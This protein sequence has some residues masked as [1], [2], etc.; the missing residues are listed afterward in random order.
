MSILLSNDE[1][2]K[3]LNKNNF[4]IPFILVGNELR[5]YYLI[6]D[7]DKGL[8]EFIVTGKTE[9]TEF[10]VF[11]KDQEQAMVRNWRQLGFVVTYHSQQISYKHRRVAI[12]Y[13]QVCEPASGASISLIPWFMVPGRPFP[14]F[15]YIYAI[16][17]YY[18]TGRKSLSVSA[19]VTGKLFGIKGFN[20]STVSRNIKAM[21]NFIDISQIDRPL[22]ADR[23][24]TLSDGEMIS[25]IPEIMRDIPSIE[26]LE[27]MYGEKVKRLPSPVSRAETVKHALSG[28]PENYSKITADRIPNDKNHNDHRKRPARPRGKKAKHVQRRLEFV[29]SQQIEATRIAFIRICRSLVLDAAGAYHQFLI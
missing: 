4:P 16:W 1:F 12:T 14:V 21:G 17:H 18:S 15:V 5:W 26:T 9:S 3:G 20:K 7:I 11:S 25:C 2:W 28:I 27:E 10:H 24:E 13:L 22:A 19:A 23:R 29:G 8:E 6:R